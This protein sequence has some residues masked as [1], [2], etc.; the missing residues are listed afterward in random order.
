MHSCQDAELIEEI[1]ENTPCVFQTNNPPY[2]SKS[3]RKKIHS[4]EDELLSTCLQELE[5]PKPE[6]ST[7]DA[8]HTFGKYVTTLLRKIP[9]GLAKEMLKIDLQQCIIKVMIPTP[10]SQPFSTIAFSDLE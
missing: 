3:K 4:I 2:S 5:R 8:D 6:A 10:V 9:D 1:E 7:S